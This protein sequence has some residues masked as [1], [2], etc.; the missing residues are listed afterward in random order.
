MCDYVGKLKRLGGI[1]L[2]QTELVALRQ[3]KYECD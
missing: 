3:T 2:F 1:C